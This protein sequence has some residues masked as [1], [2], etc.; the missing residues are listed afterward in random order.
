MKVEPERIPYH[1]SKSGQRIHNQIR[2]IGHCT[3][4]R[5][6]CI[7]P[8][9]RV[10]GLLDDSGEEIGDKVSEIRDVVFGSPPEESIDQIRWSSEGLTGESLSKKEPLS[11]LA[12]QLELH[13]IDYLLQTGLV[14]N[15]YL[16]AISSHV[17]YLGDK[18]TVLFVLKRLLTPL[19]QI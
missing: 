2:T 12:D 8:T 3:C 11:W 19:E 17:R 4:F 13:R 18:D 16:A 9:G 7:P 5:Y 14:E 1:A 10:T 15:Q 6:A